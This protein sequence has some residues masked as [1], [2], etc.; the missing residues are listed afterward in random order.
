[1]IKLDCSTDNLVREM[2]KVNINNCD[3]EERKAMGKFLVDFAP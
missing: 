3:P 2:A 1:M